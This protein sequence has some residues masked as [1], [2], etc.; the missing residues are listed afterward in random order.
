M[1]LFAVVTE[2]IRIHIQIF[3][4]SCITDATNPL[5]PTMKAKSKVGTI[6]Q[7]S[8]SKL[9]EASDADDGLGKFETD[10]LVNAF[11]KITNLMQQ[12]W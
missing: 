6:S 12:C 2:S 10:Q 3:E 8:K 5:N 11:T 9:E 7:H 1:S 4:Y